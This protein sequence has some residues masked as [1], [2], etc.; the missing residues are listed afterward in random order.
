MQTVFALP[1]MDPQVR[2]AKQYAAGPYDQ[3]Q[4]QNQQDALQRCEQVHPL[5]AH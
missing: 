2:S 3:G 4:T 1:W 5:I